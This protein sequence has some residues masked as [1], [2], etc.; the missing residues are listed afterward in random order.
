[1]LPRAAFD[2]GIR[3]GG[4]H[5]D[6]H[7]T[8]Q[9]GAFP[10]RFG[11]RPCSVFRR[12]KQDGPYAQVCTPHAAIR[13]TMRGLRHPW[14]APPIPCAGPFRSA[15][16]LAAQLRGRRHLPAAG[17]AE[18]PGSGNRVHLR[19]DA[20]HRRAADPDRRAGLCGAAASGRVLQRPRR[21]RNRAVGLRLPGSGRRAGAALAPARADPDRDRVPGAAAAG[22][23]RPADAARGGAGGA[24]RRCA[25]AFRRGHAGGE[26][27]RSA[28]RCWTTWTWTC[29]SPRCRT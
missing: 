15:H 7:G 26:A 18:G 2:P 28:A 1:M 11:P 27:R 25:E 20:Q 9:P 29:C 13:S 16:I 22:A 8:R 12:W 17:Q 24:G 21:R 19:D 14:R 6:S 5:R 3:R 23:G 4:G 10:Q